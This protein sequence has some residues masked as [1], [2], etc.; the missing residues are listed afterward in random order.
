MG[1]KPLYYW[2]RGSLVAFASE[3]KAMRAGGLCP[4]EI[5]PESLDC[6]LSL[7]YVP[8]PRTIYREVRKLLAAR[9]LLVSSSGQTERRYWSLSFRDSVERSLDDAADEFESLLDDA[10]GKRLMSEVPLG[11]FLSGGLDSSLVVSSMSRAMGRP[12]VTNS[13]GFE[14]REL[15]ELTLAGDIAKHLNTDHRRVR[16]RAQSGGPVASNRLAFRRALR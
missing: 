13:I 1:K 11:A 15:N 12:V 14:D 8:A 10:V 3:L 6:Y 9:S 7:G 4:D 2:R 16:R 5:D